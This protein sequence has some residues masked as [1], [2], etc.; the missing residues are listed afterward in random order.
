MKL[1][2]KMYCYQ[3]TQRRGLFQDKSTMREETPM[4]LLEPSQKLIPWWGYDSR[5]VREMVRVVRAV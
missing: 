5:V 2:L 3:R 1:F 4:Q